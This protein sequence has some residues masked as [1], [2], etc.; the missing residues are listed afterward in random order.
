MNFFGSLAPDDLYTNTVLLSKLKEIND[1]LLSCFSY[2]RVELE[3][4]AK[5][6]EVNFRIIGNYELIN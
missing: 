1:R 3:P 2:I 6:G 4:I 5:D